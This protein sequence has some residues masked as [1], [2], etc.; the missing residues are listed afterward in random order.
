M[1]TNVLRLNAL[2]D[3]RLLFNIQVSIVFCPFVI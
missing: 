2:R 3:F 1:E